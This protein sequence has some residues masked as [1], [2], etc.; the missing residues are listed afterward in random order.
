[1]Y[2]LFPEQAG[3]GADADVGARANSAPPTIVNV[4]L[5]VELP[6]NG[7]LLHIFNNNCKLGRT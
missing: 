1:M 3:H 2:H 5:T 4:E 6:P 7:V